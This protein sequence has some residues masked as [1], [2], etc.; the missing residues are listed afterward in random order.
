MSGGEWAGRGV[1]EGPWCVEGV[2][3][4]ARVGRI[5][6]GGFFVRFW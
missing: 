3:E 2:W 6:G 4:V 1:I 5:G